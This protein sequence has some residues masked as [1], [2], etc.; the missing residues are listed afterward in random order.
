VLRV[1]VPKAKQL[2]LKDENGSPVNQPRLG[3]QMTAGLGNVRY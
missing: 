1:V 2:K 3:E